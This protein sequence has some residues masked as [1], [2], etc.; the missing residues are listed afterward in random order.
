[1]EGATSGGN[2][3]RRTLQSY[4]VGTSGIY[5]LSQNINL[6]L[7]VLY[8]YSS[9]ITESGT[10]EFSSGTIVSPGVRY[11]INIGKLQIVPGLAI[12][13]TFTSTTRDINVFVYLSFEHPF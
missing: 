10:V 11:A 8:N 3:V 1:V 9:S 6:M 12:P 7:E 4:S 5:L 13:I 2:S